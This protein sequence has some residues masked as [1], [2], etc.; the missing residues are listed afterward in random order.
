[1][2]AILATTLIARRRQMTWA[3][4]MPA[5]WLGAN[6]VFVS[7]LAPLFALLACFTALEAWRDDAYDAPLA[8]LRS[9]QVGRR[10]I[11]DALALVAVT[12]PF[13]VQQGRCL[14]IPADWGPDLVAAS[15]LEP[16]EVRGRLIVPFDWGE[17][18]I[19]HWGPRLRVSIDGRRET[20]YSEETIRT[21][22]ALGQGRPDGIASA[23]ALR[24]EYAWLHS[25]GDA[26]AARWFSEH[27][28]EIDVRT[29]KSVIARRSDLPPLS[30]G[31]PLS[32]CAP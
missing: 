13:G 27:G 23:A 9:A 6:G 4:T 24:P 8:A 31:S 29:A 28:Y 21:Q 11:V 32:S 12:V 18:A 17:Y 16:Q 7:R 10:W 5:L 25:D 1:M 14:E 26:P 19:W 2:I 22:Q 3:R 30:V 15:A 20:I